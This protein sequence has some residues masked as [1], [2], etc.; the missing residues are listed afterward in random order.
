MAEDWTVR[1][2]ED[3]ELEELAQAPE[4]DTGDDEWAKGLE[5]EESEGD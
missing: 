4:H 2:P 5:P 3:G 1:D